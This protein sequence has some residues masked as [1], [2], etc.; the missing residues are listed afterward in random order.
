[1]IAL[2][3]VELKNDNL[4]LIDV[5]TSPRR[6]CL[7]LLLSGSKITLYCSRQNGSFGSDCPRR[8]E[9]FLSIYRSTACP[10]NYLDQAIDFIS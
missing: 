3:Y 5:E 6:R 7:S 1:M 4:A 2:I 10:K 9:Y 8:D